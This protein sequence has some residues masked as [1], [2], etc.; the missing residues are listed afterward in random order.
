MTDIEL[1]RTLR[2]LRRTVLMLQ[3]ELRN[4]H[5]DAALL[6]E[7]DAQMERGIG[8]DPRC[9][10]LRSAVDALREST[11]TPRAELMR[12]AA[13]TCEQLKDAIEEVVVRL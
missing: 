2:I 1:A 10:R 12:D 13:R 4:D 7:I 3:T 5:L 9:T 11:L 8:T 6:D